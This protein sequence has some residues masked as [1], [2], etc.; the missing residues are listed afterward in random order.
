MKIVIKLS[1]LVILSLQS[2]VIEESDKPKE[3]IIGYNLTREVV[4]YIKNYSDVFR[5]IY[6]ADLWKKASN[7]EEKYKIEDEYF[8]NTKLRESGDI[9]NILNHYEIN[10]QGGTLDTKEWIVK[11]VDNDIKYYVLKKVDDS[12]ELTE[13]NSLFPTKVNIAFKI[14]RKN[15]YY[16]SGSGYLFFYRDQYCFKGADFKIKEPINIKYNYYNND[17]I[18]GEL[19]ITPHDSQGKIIKDITNVIFIDDNNLEIFFRNQTDLY[20]GFNNQYYYEW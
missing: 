9:L 12:F 13:Y 17:L 14:L 7:I 3:T 10:T 2:C 19:N 11:E 1:L 16:V 4:F 18:D 8:Q 6:A 15:E 20:Y 5:S